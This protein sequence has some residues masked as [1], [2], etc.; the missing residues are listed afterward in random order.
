MLLEEN[1]FGNYSINKF[2][3]TTSRLISKRLLKSKLDEAL[4]HLEISSHIHNQQQLITGV[5]LLLIKLL[6]IKYIFKIVKIFVTNFF[7][8]DRRRLTTSAASYSIQPQTRAKH[9]AQFRENKKFLLANSLVLLLLISFKS[10]N[11]CNLWSASDC[12]GAPTVA[13]E[14]VMKS[15][16]YSKEQLYKYCD[17]GK[18]YVDCI[19]SKLK[20]CD[21]KPELRGALSAHEKNL[22]KT[23]WKLGPYCA[24]LG[25]SNVINYKCRTTTRATTT[26][27]GKSTKPTMPPCQIEKVFI[28]L[29]N[30]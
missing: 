24:G 29:L 10:V 2:S 30:Y 9:H 12:Q 5:F 18:A 15:D 21:L 28:Y 16:D 22:Q 13:E 6:L 3:L 7:N 20:C 26:T 1:I 14:E 27:T 23:A 8:N 25:E 11:G 19:N 17:K 4:D